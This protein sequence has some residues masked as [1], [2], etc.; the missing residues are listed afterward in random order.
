MLSILLRRPY[1]AAVWYLNKSRLKQG[2]RRARREPASQKT[3]PFAKEIAV[4]RTR[5]NHI[6]DLF[7]GYSLPNNKVFYKTVACTDV[8]MAKRYLHDTNQPR[9][10][11]LK[12]GTPCTTTSPRPRTQAFNLKTRTTPDVVETHSIVNKHR[13]A[14]RTA[15]RAHGLDAVLGVSPFSVASVF[16]AI[17][18][19]SRIEHDHDGGPVVEQVFRVA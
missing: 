6:R 10:G 13:Y 14:H 2:S 7:A 11:T 18:F 16:P 1:V 15:L 12:C 8:S 19:A 5:E 4:E 3:V 17:G 9:V